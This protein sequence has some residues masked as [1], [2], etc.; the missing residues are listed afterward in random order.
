MPANQQDRPGCS[1]IGGGIRDVGIGRAPTILLDSSTQRRAGA[2]CAGGRPRSPLLDSRPTHDPIPSRVPV[3][4]SEIYLDNHS[5]T[6]I[7]PR[8]VAVMAEVLTNKFGNPNSPE[9]A[10]GRA[11]RDAVEVA[12]RHVAELVGAPPT[13]VH[14]V[15][16]A[17]LALGHVLRLATQPESSRLLATQIAHRALLGLL[18]DGLRA[19]EV[20]WISVHPNGQIDQRH[21]RRLL[22]R[23]ADLV[24]ITLANNEIGTI[25]PLEQLVEMIATNGAKILV[26][27]SQAAGRIPITF[28]VAGLDYL[29]I[30]SHKMYGPKGAAALIGRSLPISP[31][32]TMGTPNTAAIAGF[33]EACRLRLAEMEEDE[34]R[35]RSLRDRLEQR[36]CCAFPDAVVHG[37]RVSRL[38]GN[39]SI[40]I[41]GIIAD[42]VVARLA[43]RVAIST[44]SACRDGAESYSHVLQGL[45][46]AAEMRE[47]TLRI[48]VG[49]FNSVSDID[50]A[51]E[52][53]V[54]TA[55]SVRRLVQ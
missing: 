8:V 35:T 13:M 39:L 20:D 48:C 54:N 29:V 15:P 14:F 27:A 49:Q 2:F 37:D 36:L 1:G 45:G 41:P 4:R 6:P 18:E 31:E 30:S 44:G 12:R 25:A 51:A 24:C 22:D 28:M 16:S 52:F 33:G 5:T 19:A 17:T 34:N 38:A 23:P 53:I 43:G 55:Q 7:D 9:H 40:A 21:L 47:Q 26:D 32:K 11:A 50:H 10:T 46:L 3:P 42:A